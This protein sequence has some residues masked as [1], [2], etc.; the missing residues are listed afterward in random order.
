MRSD[1]VVDVGS[2]VTFEVKSVS[3]RDEVV[4]AS[5]EVTCVWGTD[6]DDH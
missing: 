2:V 5:A 1:A 4:G 6:V 3:V